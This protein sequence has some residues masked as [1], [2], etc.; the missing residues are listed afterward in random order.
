MPGRHQ[1][2][3]QERARGGYALHRCKRAYVWTREAAAAAGRLSARKR[4]AARAAD[5][6]SLS[7]ESAPE[8]FTDAAVC[9][10]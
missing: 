2:T 8:F 5:T 10:A 4:Q 7:A 9:P 3:T 1:L 6:E